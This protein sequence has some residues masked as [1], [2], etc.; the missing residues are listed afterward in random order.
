MIPSSRYYYCISKRNPEN[1]AYVGVY[2]HEKPYVVLFRSPSEAN[3]VRVSI[4]RIKKFGPHNAFIERGEHDGLQRVPEVAG[5]SMRLGAAMDK[6]YHA[7]FEIGRWSRPPADGSKMVLDPVSES[8]VVSLLERGVG[9]AMMWELAASSRH[10]LKIE[11]R[12]LEPTH[13]MFAPH[14]IE[15]PWR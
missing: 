4:E 14:T 7:H 11:C 3:K 8:D 15:K 5:G 13:E 10:H 12:L 9:V 2:Y 6:T 1:R